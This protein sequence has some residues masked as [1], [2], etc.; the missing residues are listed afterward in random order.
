[1][2]LRLVL[3]A[4]LGVLVLVSAVTEVYVRHER[5]ARFVELNALETARDAMQVQWGRL[6]LE[7][8]TWANL[9]RIERLAH[10]R[11]ALKAPSPGDLVVVTRK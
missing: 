5:R 7:Q 2:K 6:Q 3:A 1:M 10:R 9:D 8:S 4:V 11:M